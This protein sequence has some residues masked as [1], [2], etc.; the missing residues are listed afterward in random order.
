M[1]T[2]EITSKLKADGEG[3]AWTFIFFPKRVTDFLGSRAMVPVSGTIAGHVFRTTLASSGNG[4]HV[5]TVS[6]ALQSAAA[7]KAGDTVKV[8]LQV[9]REQRAVT[10][11]P[12]LRDA[13]RV[14]SKATSLWK[15]ITP[16]AREEWIEWISG[17][18]K[19]DTRTRR[20]A[21]AISKLES[22]KRRA[23]E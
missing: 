22:G 1:K 14:S 16:R 13:L 8:T 7:I 9:D 4:T 19:A 6:K 17:A 10:I 11:P 2:L 21:G 5:M 23:Y 3:A 18:K 12:D 15:S 20:V